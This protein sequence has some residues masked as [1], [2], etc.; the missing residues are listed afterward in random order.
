MKETSDN[1]LPLV[2]MISIFY[3]RAYCVAESVQSMVDQN[4]PNLEIILVDDGS[5]DNTL[6]ELNKFKSSRVKIISHTNRGFTRSIRETIGSAAHGEYIAI[7]GSGDY[8]FPERVAR[9]VAHL[10]ENDAVAA[11]GVSREILDEQTG[12]VKT[13]RLDVKIKKGE[14][15][16][17]ENHVLSRRGGF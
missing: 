5:T 2:S 9:Q 11:C 4:Y 3:N 15:K 1:D 16:A 7:H 14:L 8:S 10:R 6:E 17:L 13:K 12:R